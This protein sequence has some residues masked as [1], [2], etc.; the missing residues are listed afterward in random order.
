MTDMQSSDQV[1][2]DYGSEQR[3]VNT[4]TQAVADPVTGATTRRTT[5][6]AWSGRSPGVEFVWLIVGIVVAFLA[7][8]F[9]LHATGANSVGFAAF[10]F[11]VGK[12][13]A[14]PFAGIFKTTNA[15]RGSLLVWA[16]V[17]A[18][19]VYALLGMVITK[20]VMMATARGATRA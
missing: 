12:A 15:T 3:G 18:M 4:T 1:V 6:R 7:F 19:F 13:L 9:V 14:A 11:S 10:V 16:D 20:I 8:D 5:T 2:S 17:L